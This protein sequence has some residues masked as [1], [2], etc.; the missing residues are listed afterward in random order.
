MEPLTTNEFKPT[1]NQS[2]INALDV[3]RGIALFGIL[4]MNINGMGLPFSYSDPSVLGHT[5]GPNYGVWFANEMFF[6]GTM[7]GLFTILFG[8]GVILLT[9]RLIDKGAGI[10]TADVYYRRIVWLL[11]FGLLNSWVFLWNGDILYAYALFGF[12]LFP[13]RNLPVKNLLIIAAVLI[14]LGMVWDVSDYHKNKDLKKEA[15]QATALKE[16]GATLDKNAEQAVAKWD[17][18][19][20]KKTSEEIQEQIDGMHGNYFEVMQ[21]K[22]SEIQWMQTWFQYRYGAW[23]ILS[24][25][26]LGMAFFKLRI[27]HGERTVKFY[28]VLLLI[29]Y[30]VGLSINYYEVR[31]ITDSNFDALKIYEASQT[32]SV[33]RLFVT[34]GHIGLFML[35]IKSGI[36]GFLQSGLAAVGRMALSNYLMHSIITSI[37]FIGFGLY[38][39]LER[40]ELYYVVFSIWIFQL[41]TSPIWLKYFQFGPFEWVWRSLTYGKKQPFKR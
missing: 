2:R 5:E 23:D 22:A 40:Y 39:Q 21:H 11:L 32:Y 31:L 8:A 27:L 37:V 1:Q 3:I 7:R 26:F 33:G 17:E 16:S 18:A 41:I 20:H 13:F 29:G 34:L 38:G 4:L 14:G 30:I 10:S 36:I 35:F 12:F 24:F 28:A 9:T 25:M 15:E 19:K 6:E